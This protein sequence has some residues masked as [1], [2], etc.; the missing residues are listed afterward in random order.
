MKMKPTLLILIALITAFGVNSVYAADVSLSF[1][2]KLATSNWTGNNTNSD[3]SF[4]Q[5]SGH[6][7]LN[8][9]LQR[10]Q[11]Y[12]GFN[13]Q[14][15]NHQFKTG[16]PERILANGSTIAATANEN[17]K[18][19]ELDLVLGYYVVKNISIFADLK[20]ISNEWTD[21]D[22]IVKMQ[23]SGL[24]LGVSG[25]VPVGKHFIFYGS[26]GSVPLNVQTDGTDVGQGRVNA[27]ELG[28]AV[29]L[30]SRNRLSFGFK[31]QRQ[32][33]EFDNGDSQKH[34]LNSFFIGYNHSLWLR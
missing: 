34:N 1:G 15:G 32:H 18:H 9:M 6:V 14:G 20:S 22:P 28:G 30:S 7:G 3:T 4:A 5:R 26:A 12:F 17:I 31:R 13:L 10:D 19:N 29:N 25:Y 11:F 16:S 33:Y 24:G 2:A 8:L 27:I 23:A 21:E